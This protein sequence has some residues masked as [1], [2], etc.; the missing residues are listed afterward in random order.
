MK[1]SANVFFV[2][3]WVGLFILL[4]YGF[5]RWHH[6]NQGGITHEHVTDA[7]RTVVLQAGRDHHF[8][9]KGYINGIKVSFLVDTGA[10]KVAV[11]LSVAKKAGLSQLYPVSIKT[12]G[13]DT[14]GYLTRINK[15]K[16]GAIELHNVS[17]LIMKQNTGSVLLGMSALKKLEMKQED[18]LL[19]ITKHR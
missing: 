19:Y 8:R 13:G 17:A 15:L 4:V 12:A 5:N 14:T 18:G 16:M 6:Q 1:K 3:I 9:L 11:P 7:K 10:S 2:L